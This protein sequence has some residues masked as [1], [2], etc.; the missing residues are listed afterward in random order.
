MKELTK[1]RRK[2][3]LLYTKTSPKVS[4]ESIRIYRPYRR[5][6]NNTSLSVSQK[7]NHLMLKFVQIIPFGRYY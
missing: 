1:M 3:R 6:P 4:L 7:I 5:S 2:R